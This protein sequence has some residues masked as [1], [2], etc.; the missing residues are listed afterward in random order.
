MTTNKVVADGRSDAEK[1]GLVYIKVSEIWRRIREKTLSLEW[2]LERL[3]DIIEGVDGFEE[4]IHIPLEWSEDL[5]IVTRGEIA[6]RIALFEDSKAKKG[7]GGS[8]RL[9]TNKELSRA[10]KAMKPADGFSFDIYFWSSTP[11]R[12][13][14]N[15]DPEIIKSCCRDCHPDGSYRLCGSHG[16]AH[17]HVHLR[18]CRPRKLD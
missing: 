12:P 4:M 2:V 3:Q 15:D 13:T 18:L 10:L 17:D 1:C 14:L 5:G 8:W 7:N 6:T 9:P 11:F 16:A